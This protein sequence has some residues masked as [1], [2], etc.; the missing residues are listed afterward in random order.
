MSP[1]KRKKI[2]FACPQHPCSTPK[3]SL[4]RRSIVESP[5]R[6]PITIP[7][8]SVFDIDEIGKNTNEKVVT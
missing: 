6:K 3:K 8:K 2:C 7:P 4:E 5:Q 1:K